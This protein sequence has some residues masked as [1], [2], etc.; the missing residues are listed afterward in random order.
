MPDKIVAYNSKKEPY[1][2]ADTGEDFPQLDFCID[3]SGHAHIIF[4]NHF[5][6]RSAHLDIAPDGSSK[7]GKSVFVPKEMDKAVTLFLK[8]LKFELKDLE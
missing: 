5:Q 8:S 7:V 3:K 1:D 2:V 4:N 6:G